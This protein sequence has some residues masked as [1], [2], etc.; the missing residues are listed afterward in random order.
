MAIT[1]MNSWKWILPALLL[2]ACA[3]VPATTPGPAPAPN[4][5]LA[6]LRQAQEETSRRL[7]VL[8]SRLALLQKQLEERPS[9]PR[10]ADQPPQMGTPSRQ[11]A[12]PEAGRPNRQVAEPQ[13]P[14]D[15]SPNRLYLQAFSLH[16]SGHY[17]EAADAFR[18]FVSR[19]PENAFAGNA[20]YWLAESFYRQHLLSRA[21]VEFEKVAGLTRSGNPG[22]TPD[23]LLRLVDIYRQLGQPVL[24]EQALQKLRLNFPDSAAARKLTSP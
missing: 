14:E 2:A 7:Q 13:A 23:A 20:Q 4:R 8:E 10:P 11:I 15:L 9:Q 24:A 22:R 18:T 1:P 19:Y 16:A 17:A 5:E 12:S 6:E 3:P 21:A